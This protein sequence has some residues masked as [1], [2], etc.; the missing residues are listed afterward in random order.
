[1]RSASCYTNKVRVE[2]FARVTKVQYPGNIANNYVKDE[3]AIACNPR[4]DVIQ[5]LHVR[6][7]KKPGHCQ[8]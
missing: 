7:G 1:M 3:A 8:K 5:Y 6:C 2:T 4:F